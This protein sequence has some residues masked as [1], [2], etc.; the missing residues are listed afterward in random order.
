MQIQQWSNLLK[1]LNEALGSIRG[2]VSVA[3]QNLVRGLLIDTFNIIITPFDLFGEG[4]EACLAEGFAEGLNKGQ[5]I[6]PN[7]HHTL[8]VSYQT[9]DA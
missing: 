1:T 3:A 2:E 8:S 7:L 4:R 9:Q 5:T 6:N